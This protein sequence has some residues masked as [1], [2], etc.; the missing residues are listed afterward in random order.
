MKRKMVF[1]LALGASVLSA[2]LHA[3][4]KGHWL[5]EAPEGYRAECSACHTLYPP[6]MLAP[7]HWQRVMRLLPQHYGTRLEL[8]P[9]VAAAIEQ[10]LLSAAVGKRAQPSQTDP[11]RLTETAYFLHKHRRVDAAWRQEV[12]SLANCEGCHQG[13]TRGVFD[14]DNL[15]WPKRRQ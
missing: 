6:E 3:G 5:A 12:K 8:S 15:I 13:A 11:P 4:I 10:Y 9:A 14:D 2:T 1:S 7:D